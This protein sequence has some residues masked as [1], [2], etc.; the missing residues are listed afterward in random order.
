MIERVIAYGDLDGPK[1]FRSDTEQLRWI[2]AN[3][4]GLAGRGP[5]QSRWPETIDPSATMPKEEPDRTAEATRRLLPEF[6]RLQRYEERAAGRRDRAIRNMM[7]IKARK[8]VDAHEE[9]LRADPLTSP[10]IGGIGEDPAFDCGSRQN[11]NDEDPSSKMSREQLA[12]FY[13]TNPIFRPTLNTRRSFTRRTPRDLFGSIGL[14]AVH[15]KSLSS[16]LTIRGPGFLNLNHVSAIKPAE[17]Y[18]VA[19]ANALN[20]LPPSAA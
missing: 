1:I 16:R 19:H 5:L 8:S 17:A 10:L 3:I 4:H 2:K 7:R 6:V 20:L 12:L 11:K 15:S 14:M 13:K 9:L 18:G